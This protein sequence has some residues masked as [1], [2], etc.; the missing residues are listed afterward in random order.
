MK[1]SVLFIYLSVYVSI[2][3][4]TNV[5]SALAHGVDSIGTMDHIHDIPVLHQGVTS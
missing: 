2:Y 5:H 1:H 4:F 3:L